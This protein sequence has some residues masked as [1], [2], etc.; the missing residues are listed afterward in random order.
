M[1]V[2]AVY[3]SGDLDDL[4]ERL[5]AA[6]SPKLHYRLN[7]RLYLVVDDLTDSV[8]D[9]L[10]LGDTPDA[11]GAVFKLNAAHNGFEHRALWEWLEVAQQVDA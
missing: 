5:E 9:I 7:K 6:Y 3:L 4:T 10:K 11:T 8:M 2:F 1:S